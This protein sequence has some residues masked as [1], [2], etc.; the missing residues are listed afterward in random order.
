ML[1]I[2]SASLMLQYRDC[3]IRKISCYILRTS[4]W[5]WSFW[6]SSSSF[7]VYMANVPQ[8]HSSGSVMTPVTGY[9][10]TG[11]RDCTMGCVAWTSD[12]TLR[13]SWVAPDTSSAPLTSN[14]FL[15]EI[16]S[17]IK[18]RAYMYIKQHCM[19]PK[20]CTR[21]SDDQ[22]LQLPIITSDQS[23]HIESLRHCTFIQWSLRL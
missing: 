23:K 14:S 16:L 2:I 4:L 5:K 17:Q 9:R 15:M 19:Q 3:V 10:L 21:C 6:I 12:V 11:R 18:R 1:A 8:W 22:Q 20:H 13:G 7:L